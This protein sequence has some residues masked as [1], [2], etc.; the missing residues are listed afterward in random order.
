[1]GL[2]PKARKPTENVVMYLSPVY[3]TP[4]ELLP[5]EQESKIRVKGLKPRSLPPPVA[6]SKEPEKP[7]PNPKKKRVM[8]PK[9]S[10]DWV[11]V[12]KAVS[13]EVSKILV[14]RGGTAGKAFWGVRGQDPLQ[15]RWFATT[16]GQI[17]LG[18]LIKL[19]EEF[20]PFAGLSLEDVAIQ[21]TLILSR[22]LS[23]NGQIYGSY[24]SWFTPS[25]ATDNFWFSPL[26]CLKNSVWG[27]FDNDID[28]LLQMLDEFNQLSSFE[29]PVAKEPFDPQ[30]LE[31]AIGWDFS[32]LRRLFD[33]SNLHSLSWRGLW[34][35]LAQR[36]RELYIQNP[37]WGHRYHIGHVITKQ[38]P[39]LAADERKDLP[40]KDEEW[41]VEAIIRLGLPG[42][43]K[44][45]DQISF[46]FDF[47]HL[48]RADMKLVA[49]TTGGQAIYKDWKGKI[50]SEGYRV[51]VLKAVTNWGKALQIFMTKDNWTELMGLW[52]NPPVRCPWEWYKQ[53]GNNLF[54]QDGQAFH[55]DPKFRP[56]V[57]WLEGNV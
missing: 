11:A 4:E 48:E 49:I 47:R 12:V 23:I 6:Q 24:R 55:P 21:T 53:W 45:P 34:L 57:M 2:A 29:I 20:G 31:E 37:G 50:H 54:G 46:G 32:P 39:S 13:P 42:G 27:G 7:S 30:K 28:S 14:N 44:L 41:K 22:I 40:K 38:L 36:Q 1:M 10:V 19:Q 18:P 51:P 35:A 16:M 17:S 56:T 43:V 3:P 52:Y 26:G 8:P 25:K 33:Y 5:P 15:H 9:V